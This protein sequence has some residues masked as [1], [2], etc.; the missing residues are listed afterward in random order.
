MRRSAALSLQ[1]VRNISEMEAY[2]AVDT[3]FNKCYNDLEPFGRRIIGTADCE[4]AF[5]DM[6]IFAN[7]NNNNNVKQ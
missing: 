7:K 4:R 1:T 3:V 5:K 6:H 2:G